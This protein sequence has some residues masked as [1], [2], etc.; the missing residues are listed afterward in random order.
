MRYC[1]MRN[2][3]QRSHPVRIRFL[4]DR[5][6]SNGY[7]STKKRPVM[8]DSDISTFLKIPPLMVNRWKRSHDYRF[9]LYH[10][11]RHKDASH[12]R[13]II[14]V[15]VD[16]MRIEFMT[17]QA[18]EEHLANHLGY[19]HYMQLLNSPIRRMT[20]EDIKKGCP[21]LKLCKRCNLIA[22]RS[23]NPHDVYAVL[24]PNRFPESKKLTSEIREIKEALPEGCALKGI[25]YITN[26]KMPPAY[27]QKKSMQMDGTELFHVNFDKF[28][29]DTI[30]K[31]VIFI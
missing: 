14:D 22:T 27:I 28:N 6:I 5:N 17:K 7:N 30:K 4:V 20:D 29:I 21:G 12:T 11:L 8:N 24:Y 10:F 25:I 2:P 19:F 23:D 31:K 16:E 1:Q 18:F 9:I 26:D 13:S 15:M 3:F